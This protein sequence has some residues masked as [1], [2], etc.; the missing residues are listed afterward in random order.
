[1]NVNANANNS[2]TDVFKLVSG[3]P[4]NVSKLYEVFAHMNTV[5]IAEIFE[6]LSSEKV[7][8]IFR[9][10][11][12]SMAADV[13]SYIES[14]NKQIIIEALTDGEVAKI[15][16]ELFVDDAVDFIDEMPANVVKRVLKNADE[17]KRRFIN[18]FLQYPDDSAGGIMT[19]EYVDLREDYKVREAFDYIRKTG[20]DKETIYTCYVIRRDKLLVGAI[21]AK[22]LMLANPY[23]RIGDIMD[24][25][26]IFAQTHDD[27][28]AVAGLFRKYGLLSLPVADKEQRLVGIITV[29]DVVQI[30]EEETTEDFEIMSGVTPSDKSYMKMSVFEIFKNR[31]PWLLLL[32]VSA[33]FTGIIISS[34]EHA[35]AVHIALGM[36]IPMLMDSAGNSGSQASV[37]VIRA[38]SLGE[39]AFS[40]LMRVVWREIRIALFCGGALAATCFVKI[41]VIDMMILQAKGVTVSVALVVSVTLAFTILCAKAIGCVMPLVANKI[42]FDPAVMASPFITT[43]ADAISLLIY[44]RI[45][46]IVLQF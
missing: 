6:N 7:I 45:A 15:M 10:L 13:F 23:D 21:S 38:I 26:I 30:I 46:T 42:G 39:L 27:Q 24:K 9:L 1:M 29:D 5:D 25:N 17:T 34:F 8:Q 14:D 2:D 11:P 22:A 35:L 3:N 12:K 40:D 28:E 43:A 4:L 20:V 44:F 36:F 33:T 19:A 16:D 31:I 41:L 32:M 18:Q 37:T